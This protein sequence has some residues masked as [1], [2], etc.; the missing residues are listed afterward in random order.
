MLAQI[1]PLSAEESL[2]HATESGIYAG[3]ALTKESK[4]GILK[5]WQRDAA[6]GL[7]KPKKPKLT[8][9]HRRMMLQAHGVRLTELPKKNKKQC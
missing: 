3:R 2:R 6:A 9:L 8:K 4:D 5:G 1:G 7:K